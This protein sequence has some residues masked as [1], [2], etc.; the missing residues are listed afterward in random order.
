MIL[1]IT[2]INL[3]RITEEQTNVKR[4]TPHALIRH[5]IKICVVNI[6]IADTCVKPHELVKC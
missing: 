5:I 3:F 1:K 2:N 6:P 4:K